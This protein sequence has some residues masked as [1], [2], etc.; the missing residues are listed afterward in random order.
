MD[1]S[2]YK[3][4]D[5]EEWDIW[6]LYPQHRWTFNK[7][8]LALKL[9]YLA[10]PCPKPVPVTKEYVV[11]P[12]YNFSGMGIGSQIKVLEKDIVY[13]SQPSY[14]W[15][16]RFIGDHISV[17]YE[18]GGNSFKELH[19][20]L[21]DTDFSNLSRFKK[22]T[23]VPN[24]EITLP[25]WINTLYDVKYLNIEFINNNPIEIHLRWGIDFPDN[26]VEIIPV[27]STTD[28]R[29]VQDLLSNGYRYKADYMD[30]EKNLSDPRLGFLYK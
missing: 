26:S 8:E 6:D 11:R 13:D 30:A 19:T 27:W 1:L 5:L 23:L 16:E 15:C 29:I 7:L 4:K 2:C 20:S 9:G 22:W 25:T 12:I 24:R 18:W 21:A 3:L 17:N 14:F 10:G 28:K